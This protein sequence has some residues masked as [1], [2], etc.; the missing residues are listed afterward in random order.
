M[1]ENSK[2]SS[3]EHRKPGSCC[4]GME[5]KGDLNPNVPSSIV[6][7]MVLIPVAA[8]LV[9]ALFLLVTTFLICERGQEENRINYEYPHVSIQIR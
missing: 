4:Y 7:L 6:V 5:T 1:K 3:A 2:Q 9:A 8:S